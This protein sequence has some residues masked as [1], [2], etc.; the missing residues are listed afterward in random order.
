MKDNIIL[1]G[2]MGCGKTSVGI[3]LSYRLKR[4][5]IDT[6]KWIEK[7]AGLT[8]SEIFE[9]SGE[10][11]FRRMETDCLQSLIRED[12]QGQILSVGGGLPLREE[13]SALLKELGTVVYLRVTAPTVCERLAGDTTRPLLMGEN[14]EEK[15]GLLLKKREPFYE[16]EADAIIDVDG[17]EY[18][19]ILD[20]IM[21]K[22]GCSEKGQG[23]N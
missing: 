5:M 19:S 23:E 10:E 9:Q 11:A 3:R 14:P 15:V 4:T 8:V 12:I 6:D 13:N 20:E 21:E 1:T 18:E 17:R 16:M 22:T 7:K 2:F